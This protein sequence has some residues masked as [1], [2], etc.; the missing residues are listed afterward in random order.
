MNYGELANIHYKPR[1]IDQMISSSLEVF[2]AVLIRGPKYC[3][4]TW[5]GRN[6][7]NSEA[8][9]MPTLENPSPLEMYKAAPSLALR[10]KSPHL[11]DEWQ[12]L[13]QLWDIVRSTVDQTAKER[14]FILTGSSTPRNNKP[15]HSGVGRIERIFLRPMTLSESGESSNEISLARLFKEETAIEGISK[16]YTPE[17]MAALAVR[18]GWPATLD[19]SFDNLQV[20]PKSYITS[21]I[22]EDM[23]KVDDKKRDKGKMERLLRSLARNTEQASTAK[24]LIKDMTASAA[25]APLA[26]E[27]IDDYMDVLKRAFILEE[28]GPWSPNV[29]SPL[30]INKKPKYHFVDP[31]LPAAI[32]GVTQQQ[33]LNDFEMFGFVFECMCTRDLL[34]YTEAMGGSL[35]YYRD[36]DDLEIDAVIQA[37]DGAWGGIEIK[38]GHNQADKAAANLLKMSN[39]IMS[40]GGRQ[41]AFL[42]VLEGLGQ[43]A[44]TREDGVHIVPLGTLC[45]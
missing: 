10:G 1:C 44:Y 29:R 23:H 21:F 9:L 43:F 37:P 12:E 8:T 3:G 5:S 27:T 7:A 34:V 30:R 38:L 41:P 24:T 22:E 32:L 18:G 45:A 33:L 28:I 14:K 35:Y 42:M 25:D 13:P 4:K 17:Q 31:S 11:I 15:S 2:G 26:D 39:K 19:V 36:R 20:L 6:H 16:R 40:A